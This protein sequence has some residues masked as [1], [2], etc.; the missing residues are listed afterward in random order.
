[1]K[2]ATLALALLPCLAPV[3]HAG[4][5]P[6]TYKGKAYTADALPHE[7]SPAQRAAVERY[8]PWA[9]KAHYR[10]DF[11]AQG[12]LLLVTPKDRPRLADAQKVVGKAETWFDTVLPPIDRAVK[13]KGDPDGG[14]PR[15]A[16]SPIPEDPESAPH[17][18]V[19]DNQGMPG[20]PVP[21]TSWGS[22]SIEPD[23]QVAVL[24]VIGT[25][26]DYSSLLD[27]TAAISSYLKD[28]IEAARKHTGFTIEEPLAGAYMENAAGQE[29]W[30][31]DH[32]LMNRTVQLLTLR[33]FGQQPNWL[34]Q[35]IAWDCEMSSDGMVYCF[36][37]RKEFV[38]TAEHGAWPGEA[39]ALV[40]DLG[41]KSID[42]ADLCKWKRGTWDAKTAKL[43]WGVAHHLIGQGP[44][45]LSSAL[46]DL[47]LVRNE[48][49]KKVT[50]PTS[51][52]RIPGYEVPPDTQLGVL[53]ERFGKDV[54]KDAT[55]SIRAGK[56]NVQRDSKTP[57]KTGTRE[58]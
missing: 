31:G 20:S 48:K 41:A 13:T 5:V 36:P 16:G 30:N 45:K 40:K 9:A 22:G 2:H 1:M 28:W 7:I 23:T 49:D 27:A 14:T 32:E 29:E 42:I 46:E 25:A 8:E 55:G 26:E 54:M 52:T 37:F 11:D 43:A 53:S 38:Y 21:Q 10:M 33:R 4:E 6:L 50:S 12:R 24:F 35:G 44:G 47:R 3:V 18:F 56:V 58:R 57:G 51:W 39:K 34:V 15:P 19:G 17:I